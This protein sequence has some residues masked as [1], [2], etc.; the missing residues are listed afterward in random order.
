MISIRMFASRTLLAAALAAPLF[1]VNPALADDKKKDP[2]EIGNR[3]VSKGIVPNWYSIEKEIALGK[4][5]AQEVER[6][7]KIVDDPI[8]AEYVNRVGQ[9]LVRNSDA[10]VP[11]TIKVIDSEEINAF[12]LPGGFFFV[13][14]G[15]LLNADNEAE[16]AGVMGHE[17]AHVAARHG[18]RQASTAQTVNLATIPLIF[19]GGWVGYG[20]RQAVGVAIP[21]G[22]LQF[23][24]GYESE[25]D[26]LGLEYMYKAG[27]DPEAFVDFFEKVQSQEKRK[28]GT[29]SKVFSTHPPTEDRIK[30]S[31]EMIQ[32]YLKAKPEYVV[33][34][35][36]FNDVKARVVAMHGRRTVTDPKDAGRPTLRRN[37]NGQI[38]SNGNETAPK[39]DSDDRPTLK[40]RDN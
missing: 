24:K 6:Q 36:E 9:N 19:M 26:M 25:A 37:P 39:S 14:T 15:I 10:K 7:A 29:M 8:I 32:K 33:S 4:Q 5:M 28:P 38:D 35:S 30:R 2:D 13:N 1:V 17:I 3:D 40:R 31:Q 22:F 27:Y 21:M 34:T 18:T 12:A 16:M 11:F 20:I 23:S